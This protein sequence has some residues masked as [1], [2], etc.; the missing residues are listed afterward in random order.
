M[1]QRTRL[2]L[3]AAA[4]LFGSVTAPFPGSGD[5]EKEHAEPALPVDAAERSHHTP[6]GPVRIDYRLTGTQALGQPFSVI[7]RVSASRNVTGLTACVYGHDG[8]I[9]S[10]VGIDL[11]DLSVD[12]VVERILTV[13]PY[14]HDARRL[15]VLVTGMIDG[16]EHA[17]QI[18]VPV[19]AKQ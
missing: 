15:S 17:A 12:D 16:Q 2:R 5:L 18:T 19:N 9:V 11:P 3:V 8:L 6:W 10:P 7:I 14:L 1:K 4:I 13:T